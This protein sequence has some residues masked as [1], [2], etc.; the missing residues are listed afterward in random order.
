MIDIHVLKWYNILQSGCIFWLMTQVQTWITW[1]MNSPKDLRRNPFFY[2]YLLINQ[3]N[4]SFKWH[5]KFCLFD[6]VLKFYLTRYAWRYLKTVKLQ[7]QLLTWA[8]FSMCQ[9]NNITFGNWLSYLWTWMWWNEAS[10]KCS[11]SSTTSLM[12]IS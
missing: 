4:H 6:I 11:T 12:Q 10:K 8:G 7:V 2:H 1:L 9:F 3:C 5:W